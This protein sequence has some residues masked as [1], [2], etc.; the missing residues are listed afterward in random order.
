MNFLS[1]TLRCAFCFGTGYEIDGL[2]RR[3][4]RVCDGAGNVD[5]TVGL[6]QEI[7]ECK[8]C[9]GMGYYYPG[10][11]KTLC[12][13]CHGT[14]QIV[15]TLK[16]GRGKPSECKFCY[17]SGAYNDGFIKKLCPRCK[18]LGLTYPKEISA[19]E[20][21]AGPQKNRG[22]IARKPG[23][24]YDIAVSFAGEDRPVVEKYVNALSTRDI[25]VF[26]DKYEKSELWG[27]DLY[28]R[29]I[30]VYK[31]KARYCVIFI[32]HHYAEKLWTN[33]ERKAAQAR[34]FKDNET[35]IL[36]VKLDDTELPG[37]HET[38]G[39][40]DLRQTPLDELVQLTIKKLSK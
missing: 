39:Y 25:K 26:Y 4:C 30:D 15:Y 8:F 33:H 3:P 27:K 7:G 1:R 2:V 23:M 28:I 18:G 6:G 19:V 40:I 35:Y 17:G 31:N 22:A 20:T 13:G 29:L 12:P 34:A 32:S 5:I 38:V 16:L 24:E 11:T 10:T 37:I 9:S 14:G 36:P 21:P